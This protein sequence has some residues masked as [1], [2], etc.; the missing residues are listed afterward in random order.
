MGHR[1]AAFTPEVYGHV[2]DGDVGPP[3]DVD[4]ERQVFDGQR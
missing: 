3:L 1:F 4:R 2:L